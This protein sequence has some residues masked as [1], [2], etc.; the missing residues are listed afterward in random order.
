MKSIRANSKL[1]FF[2]TGPPELR[3][4]G[5][6]DRMVLVGETHQREGK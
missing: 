5:W 4:S 3:M 2:M 6:Y 1:K